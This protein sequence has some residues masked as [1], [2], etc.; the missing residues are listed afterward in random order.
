MK[1][2]CFIRGKVPMTKAPI[3][4]V[5]LDLLE[6]HQA[7]RFLDIGAGTGSIS[8]Q[9]AQ[10][11][12]DLDVYAIEHKEAAVDLI[13]ENRAH[14]GLKNYQVFLGEAPMTEDLGHFDA[15]FIGGSGGKLLEIIDWAY[16]LLN[17]GGRLVLTF[18]LM[19]NAHK[20]ITYL[21]A[22]S[23]QDLEVQTLQA[24]TR[25]TMGPGHYFKPFNPTTIISCKK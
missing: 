4:A 6:L 19:E 23:W 14:F 17:P 24:A 16:E 12:P 15:I 7:R 8:L 18:I 1:D 10:E 11:Y 5:A 2:S 9:A 22:G 21:E 3:R 25:K 13:K 20:A